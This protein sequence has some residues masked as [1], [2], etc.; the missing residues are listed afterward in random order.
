M[1]L[2]LSILRASAVNFFALSFCLCVL[3]AI[4]C[5]YPSIAQ[6]ISASGFKL[7]SSISD[8]R[9][10]S[11]AQQSALADSTMK[12]GFGNHQSDELSEQM[13]ETL[14]LHR[15]QLCRWLAEKGAFVSPQV[16]AHWATA[17]TPR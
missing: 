6:N 13:R 5:V 4:V 14:R 1:I 7:M 3:F 15:S 16:S 9:V 12:F 11:S 8:Q 10:L 17:E 2:P